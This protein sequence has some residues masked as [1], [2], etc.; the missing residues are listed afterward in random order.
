MSEEVH[1]QTSHRT[2]GGQRSEFSSLSTVSMDE[3]YLSP[4]LSELEN[5]ASHQIIVTT[6]QAMPKGNIK[7]GRVKHTAIEGY[8]ALCKARRWRDWSVRGV[9]RDSVWRK[10]K[11]ESE[12]WE[13]AEALT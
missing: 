3:T 12:I 8:Y 5:A 1:T 6:I 10:E 11:Y 2:R 9:T 13:R 7:G 4:R